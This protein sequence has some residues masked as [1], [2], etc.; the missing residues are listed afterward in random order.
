MK[1]FFKY[2]TL[3]SLGGLLYMMIEILFSGSTHWTMGILGGLCF[4][5]IGLINSTFSYDFSLIK[6]MAMSAILIT[7]LEFV[8]GVILNLG[9]H[10]AIWDYSHLPFNILG[11]VCLPFSFIWFFLSLPAIFLD[12]FIRWQLFG[13]GKPHYKL[14]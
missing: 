12:D 5:L 9:L 3:F 11:Q 2:F 8:A 1:T 4:L 13:E 10:L 6:Q 7:A 14:F